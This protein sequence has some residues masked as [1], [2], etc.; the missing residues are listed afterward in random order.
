VTAA[1]LVRHG[2]D[3]PVVPQRARLGAMVQSLVADLTARH[4]V[5]RLG[6]EEVRWQG[7]ALIGADGSVTALTAGEERVL[8]ELLA[9]APGVVAK[10]ELVDD[11]V[12]EHAAEAAV[13]RLRAKLGTLGAGIRVVRRRGYVCELE[14]AP[15][16]PV[17]AGAGV[18][19]LG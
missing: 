2:V 6:D 8:D 14:A 3:G 10:G 15:L 13:A 18:E 5:L 11:G 9:R 16:V 17:G 12:D 7:S 1:A 19:A 4:R